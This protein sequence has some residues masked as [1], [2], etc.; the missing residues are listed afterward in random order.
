MYGPPSPN[1]GAAQAHYG[2]VPGGG[3]RWQCGFC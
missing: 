2:P 3:K 1:V